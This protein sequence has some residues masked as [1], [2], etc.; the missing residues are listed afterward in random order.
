M[1]GSSSFYAPPPASAPP[2]PPPDRAPLREW[3]LLVAV[4]VLSLVAGAAGGVAGSLLLARVAPAI[5]A[6]PGLPVPTPLPARIVVEESNAITE[7]VREVLPAVATIITRT[8]QGSTQTGSGVVVDR[9]RGLVL[10][11]SH[12]IE[13]ARST[14]PSRDIQVILGSGQRLQATV[15]GNDA[16]TDVAVLRVPAPLPA[17][18][19]LGDAT[20]LPLGAH[21]VAIGSPVGI[22]Q[23]SV[24]SGIVSAKA[25]RLARPDLRDIFLEDL[26]QTDAA[27]NVGNSG[28]PLVWVSTRQVIGINTI[29]FR[30]EGEEGLGFAISSN[31]VRRIADE[32]IAKG[33]V[34][35]GVLGVSYDDNNAR[36][37]AANRLP[38][39][40]GV[41]V[42]EVFPGLPAAQAGLRAGDLITKLGGQEIDPA[43]RPLRTL[44][45]NFRPGDRVSVTF[46]RQG[47]ER[48]VDLTLA[49]P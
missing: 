29:V 43:S 36:F 21:V 6:V 24:T 33:K 11:N 28:G 16:F 5:P 48:T 13:E 38:T 10:T 9:E 18:A 8:P 17:Q 2:P 14:R 41:V 46:I 34:V 39:D 25:R 20:D 44:L 26:I 1:L 45:L 12:V 35:R 4:L 47:Q 23:N 30:H 37:A 49:E 31:T 27:I 22:F 15:V 7:A 40:K 42:L 32:L 19:L 3:K